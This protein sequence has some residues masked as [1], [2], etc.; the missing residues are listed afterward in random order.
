MAWLDYVSYFFG[1]MFLTNAVPHFVNGVSGR[2]FQSPFAKP[3]G[4]GLSSSSLNVLWG[5]MNAVVGYA[6]V[7]H[8]GNFCLKHTTDA[9]ALGMG[10][11]V[12]GVGIAR[13]FGRFHGG[14]SPH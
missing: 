6:L 11:L 14:N 4:E 3:P 7:C 2:P 13:Y 1:G 12:A 9:V 8:V 5:V 10:V